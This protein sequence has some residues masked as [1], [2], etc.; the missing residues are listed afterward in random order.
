[1]MKRKADQLKTGIVILVAFAVMVVIVIASYQNYKRIQDNVIEIEQQ[2]LLSLVETVA[3]SIENFFTYQLH[4]LE[5]LTKSRSFVR[6]IEGYDKAGYEEDPFRNL[7]DY[8]TIQS[9]NIELIRLV[10]MEGSE[11]YT[12]PITDFSTYINTDLVRLSGLNESE[13]G[14]QEIGKIYEVSGQLYVNILH[15]VVVKNELSAVLYIKI[16]LNTIY[17]SLVAPVRA[18]VKGYASVKDSS[19]VLIMHPNAEDIGENVIEARTSTYPDFDWSELEL[20]VE[21]QKNGESGVGIY[22]SLWFTDN[23]EKRVKKF[24]AYAPAQIG[25]DFWIINVSKDYVEVV[26]FLKER[27]YTIIINNFIIILTFVTSAFVY[28]RFRRDRALIKKERALLITVKSLNEELTRSKNKF[29]K[30]F[31][32][33]SDCIFVISRTQEAEI[34]EVNTKVVK[35]LGYSKETLYGKSYFELS[36]MLTPHDFADILKTLDETD[37]AI[38]EDLLIGENGRFIPVEINARLMINENQEQIVM[39]SR[40]ISMKKMFEQ[41]MEESKKKEALMI[42][43]SRLAAMGEMIGSIAHQWRQPLS[44][45]AMIYSNL[46]DAYK[47][48]ELD[49]AFLMSQG[50]RHEE[51]VKFM[52]NTIDD[53]RFFFDPKIDTKDFLISSVMDRTLDFLKETIRLNNIEIHYALEMDLLMHGRP[54]QLSQVLFSILKNAIDAIIHNGTCERHV[55]IHIS[56]EEGTVHLMIEDSAGGTEINNLDKLFDAYFTTK[57][58]QNGTGLGLYISKV[59]VEK[60][61][62]GTIEATNTN[63]GLSVMI[64]MPLEQQ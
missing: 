4:N 54:N 21:K 40:D 11:I 36:T 41:E 5:I 50:Q 62:S 61:F 29:E 17:H 30:I 59:I 60:N 6:D 46:I 7:E 23:D 56:K 43:Q 10:D 53:F 26:E 49:E 2:Q 28:Y 37:N 12:Y 45:I 58:A 20:L 34:I 35:S 63:N 27:T 9:K 15:P 64:S 39:I 42:Y 22:H 47:Y 52:S 3:K 33:G 25:N 44:G 19:G 16:K 32:S 57:D 13:L 14:T 1:M 51:L 8:Y 18:G 24:S 55:W 48:G 38:F 31:E